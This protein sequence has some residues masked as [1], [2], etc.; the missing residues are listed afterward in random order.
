MGT[1]M[2]SSGCDLPRLMY[3]GGMAAK[4]RNPSIT[5]E[6]GDA[7]RSEKFSYWMEVR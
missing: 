4:E 1:S 6:C 2:S 3:G 7:E 5:Y